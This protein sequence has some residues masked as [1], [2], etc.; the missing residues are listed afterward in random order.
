M[1]NRRTVLATGALATVPLA[2]SLQAL[3]QG[4]KD[5]VTLAM[6][7][8]PPGLDPTAGA[9]SSIGEITLYNVFEPLT[10]INADGSV[11]P[12][13]AESWEVSP[14]LKTYTFKLRAGVKFHNG[15]PFNAAAVK[16]SFDRAAGEKSTN[17]DK[18]TF[19]NLTT[20][21]VDDLTVVVINK[22][23]D[24]DLLFV[25]GQATA[26][27]VE[28]GS[29]D[30]NATKPVGTGP[31]RLESWSKGASV[32]LARWDGYRT[33]NAVHIRRATFRFIS[34]P[35]AQV[36]ALMAGDVDAFPRVTPRSVAQF[37]ANPRF[38]VI[39]SGSWAKTIL[40]I[41]QQKKPL[42]DVRV[43][44]A[45]AAAI[46]RKAVIQGAGDGLGV[47]IGSHYVPGAFGYLDTT[48][49][50]PFDPEKAKKLL[51]EA[52]VKT[53]LELTMT[54]PPTPYA[55][56]GGEVIAAQLAKVGIVA[57][58]QNVEW[59]QWLSGTYGNKNY[60]LTLISH[61]E[62][63]DLGNFAKPDYYWGY[64]SPQFNA[65]YEQIKNAARPA[66]RARLLGDAQRLLA[67]D[68]VHA[69]LYQPQW[70]TVANK[71]LRGLWKD[72]PIF[73]NDLSAL[74]WS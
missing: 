6:T 42:D 25:L 48:G 51:A 16:F 41:N 26:V 17:K 13:L 56:Q 5:A 33:A 53:P 29:A 74:S 12:L 11:S 71:N 20:Q 27:I 10:K 9:A 61:V 72:M 35:A 52:G 50:N 38:Q 30:A 24:P 58:L 2:T 39:V 49:I 37:K 67:E 47:P 19:A 60:D 21:A 70:V 14:D 32:T 7:L 46:D 1:L 3:A 66:D 54:L 44:R 34:D 18:R 28:P 8:E 45:I 69:F 73:V 64:N 62:P 4:K 43:R 31:Y 57:K 15:A 63:F 22:D 65:L 36:A 40:A 23:I 59:A 55:R 68:S